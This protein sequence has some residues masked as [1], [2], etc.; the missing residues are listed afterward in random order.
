[1]LGCQ[2]SLLRKTAT[3][4]VTIKSFCGEGIRAQ[5]DSQ[6]NEQNFHAM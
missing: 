2:E 4:F 1:V 5:A 6:S 3:V